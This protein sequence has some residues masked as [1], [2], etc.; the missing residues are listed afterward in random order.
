M[1]DPKTVVKKEPRKSLIVLFL[2]AIF[3]IVIGVIA[4]FAPGAQQTDMAEGVGWIMILIG[5]GCLGLYIY[6]RRE[7]PK[8]PPR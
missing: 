1:D 2:A 4:L 8:A 7:R 3:T 5:V 6:G